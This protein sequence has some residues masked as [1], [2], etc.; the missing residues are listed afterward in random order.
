[1]TELKP[2]EIWLPYFVQRLFHGQYGLGF[3]L[4]MFD[5]LTVRYEDNPAVGHRNGEGFPIS[6]HLSVVLSERCG[7]VLRLP[8]YTRFEEAFPNQ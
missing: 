3:A 1:M 6:L 2:D 8:T 7:S 5:L 4:Q